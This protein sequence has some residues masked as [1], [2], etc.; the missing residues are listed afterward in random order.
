[1]EICGRSTTATSTKSG[2]DGSL[3]PPP[4]GVHPLACC[5]D[6]VSLGA[7]VSVGP[8]AV[9]EEGAVVG[10]LDN[11]RTLVKDLDIDEVLIT[12]PNLPHDQIFSIIQDCEREIREFRIVPDLLELVDAYAKMD[13]SAEAMNRAMMLMAKFCQENR[14][15]PA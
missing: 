14:K 4:P 6:G 8:F 15:A 11:L 3:A 10:S 12:Q 7:G 5:A 9:V 13:G 1:L 2:R